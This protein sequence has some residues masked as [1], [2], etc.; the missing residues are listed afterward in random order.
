MTFAIRDLSVLAYAQGFSLWLYK[1]SGPV[2]DVREPGFF[3]DA[4]TVF[5]HGDHIHIKAL[6]GGALLRINIEGDNVAVE[7][8]QG[9]AP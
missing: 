6:D 5:A 7:A 3:N 2:A 9:G 1:H 8:L 4:C